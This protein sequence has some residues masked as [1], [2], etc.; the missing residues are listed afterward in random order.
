MVNKDQCQIGENI[1][2]YGTFHLE[3]II[4]PRNKQTIKENI[5]KP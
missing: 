5:V 4:T 1:F 2:H 3:K